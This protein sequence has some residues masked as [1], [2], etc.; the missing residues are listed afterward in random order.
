MTSR[1]S[2]PMTLELTE[3]LIAEAMACGEGRVPAGG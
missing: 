3:E 1:V 2:T